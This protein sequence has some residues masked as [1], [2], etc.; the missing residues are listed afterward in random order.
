MSTRNGVQLSFEPYAEQREVLNDGT[1]FR[2]VA[3][4]RRS[5]KTLMAAVETVRR[6]LNGPDNW[7]GYWVGAEHHH[8]DTAYQL[9]NRVLPEEI[10][11][12]RNKSPPR[13]IELVGGQTIEFHT[14]G[15]GAL[16]SIGLDW[17]VCD[18]AGKEFPESTWVQELRPALSDREGDAMFISTPDGRGWFYDRWQRGQTDDYPEWRSWRWPAYANPH[19][20]DEEID[21]AKDGIPERIF[22]QEYLAEFVDE[23]GGVFEDLDEHLFTADY[24]LPLPPAEATDPDAP[25]AQ[26]PYATGVDFARHQDYRVAVTVDAAGRIVN[27]ERDQHETWPQIQQAVEDIAERYPGVVA[28]DA[29]RDN[30]IVADLEAAGVAVDPVRFS[31]QRKRELI[32]NLITAIENEELSAPE[33]PALRSE[34]EVFEYD[35]TRGGNIRYDAPEGFHDDTV[36]AL[37]L[38]ADARTE[39]ARQGAAATARV[40]EDTDTGKGPIEDAVAEYQREYRNATTNRWK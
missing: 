23:T 5:G 15:G 39:A 21:S 11:A 13:V 37:A 32:E 10:V 29:S 24:D 1:R 35:V 27:F 26:P 3:A 36:D 28:V 25:A 17:A 12:T 7:R 22:R 30:K 38:A 18:E 16:V 33:I 40:G 34:L 4:G 2:V 9:I 8:A 31:P 6:M 19:V 14:S 20:A